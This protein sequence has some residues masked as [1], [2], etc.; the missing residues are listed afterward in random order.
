MSNA[1]LGGVWVASGWHHIE[2]QK[3]VSEK[4]RTRES[5]EGGEAPPRKAS[6]FF[7]GPRVHHPTRHQFPQ[8]SD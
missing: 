1:F 4:R 3:Q 2:Q 8:G 6:S 5:T 7:E